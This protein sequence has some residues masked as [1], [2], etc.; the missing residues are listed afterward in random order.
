MRKEGEEERAKNFF[1]SFLF[2]S[3]LPSQQTH[4][5][6]GKRE[7]TG[8]IALGKREGEKVAPTERRKLFYEHTFPSRTFP[9]TLAFEIRTAIVALKGGSSDCKLFQV[10]EKIAQVS[11]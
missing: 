4:E 8:L 7:R 11:A 6:K 10:G 9:S 5:G 1:F 3:L 2:L